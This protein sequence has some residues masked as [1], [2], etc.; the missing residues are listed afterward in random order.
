M[1]GNVGRSIVTFIG[2]VMLLIAYEV[3]EKLFAR[4]RTGKD[5]RQADVTTALPDGLT[6]LVKTQP[7]KS[8]NPNLDIVLQAGAHD[9]IYEVMDSGPEYLVGLLK[10]L[11]TIQT[12]R[13]KENHLGKWMKITGRVKDVTEPHADKNRMRLSIEG[14]DK[15][16]CDPVPSQHPFLYL[17][18]NRNTWY[19]R[20]L[21]L[22][23]GDPVMVLGQVKDFSLHHI[24]LDDCELTAEC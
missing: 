24:S 8:E 6:K 18:F 12:Q 1:L 5:E 13:L 22:K 19:H 11:T 21:Q 17:D 14:Y 2:V 9:A 3:P 20:L 4:R 23:R 16:G 10:G 7:K 15:M